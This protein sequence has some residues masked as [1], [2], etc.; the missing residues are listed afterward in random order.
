[1]P[2]M[3]KPSLEKV[4]GVIEPTIFV[5]LAQVLIITDKTN[6]TKEYIS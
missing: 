6:R 1:M 4:F 2:Y 3:E 5:K